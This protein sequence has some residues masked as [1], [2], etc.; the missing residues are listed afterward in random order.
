[1]IADGRDGRVDVA[2]VEGDGV[3]AG[4]AEL[5]GDIRAVSLAR[6]GQGA[7]EEDG[8]GTKSV[9]AMPGY[10]GIGKTLGGAPGSKRMGAGWANAYFEHIEDG[11]AFVR[12]DG[13]FGK[14]NL[15]CKL[16]KLNVAH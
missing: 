16:S 6:F 12:Q 8:Y 14:G 3:F 15:F 11:D 13:N 1:M 4:E 2:G 5:D 9:K 7:V 10:Q